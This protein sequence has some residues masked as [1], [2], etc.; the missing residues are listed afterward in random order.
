[1]AF[2]QAGVDNLSRALTEPAADIFQR[3]FAALIFN[4]IV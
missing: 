3:R 1:L 4:A 2:I